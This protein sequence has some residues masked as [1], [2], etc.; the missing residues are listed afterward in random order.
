MTQV[1]SRII[2]DLAERMNW[3]EEIGKL[4]QQHNISVLQLNRWETL[5]EDHIAK[6]QQTGLDGEFIKAIFE[7]IHAQAVKKQ[8]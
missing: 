4:K 3:V 2:Q 6:A 8:L 5:L 1:D 7:L